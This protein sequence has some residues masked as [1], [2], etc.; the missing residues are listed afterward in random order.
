MSVFGVFLVRIFP[1]SDWI[2]YL[3]AFSPNAEKYG[4][5]K[6]RIRTLSMQ[7]ILNI[8]WPFWNSHLERVLVLLSLTLNSLHSFFLCFHCYLNKQMSFQG[9]RSLTCNNWWLK[10]DWESLPYT[11]RFP[12]LKCLTIILQITPSG[13]CA[14]IQQKLSKQFQ[15]I[16][17]TPLKLSHLCSINI[18]MEQ[19]YERIIVRIIVPWYH[20]KDFV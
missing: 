5:E 14:L 3:P 19:Q 15:Q 7:R 20:E 9:N 1:H 6:F 10:K 12:C 17:K 16:P 11:I 8:F 2:Q 13:N 4:P 18:T